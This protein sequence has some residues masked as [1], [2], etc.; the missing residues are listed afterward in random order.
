ML[1]RRPIRLSFV[2][3]LVVVSS[4]SV[5]SA[6]RVERTQAQ[7]YLEHV[8]YLA[9]PEL[10]GRGAG[11]PGLDLASKYIANQLRQFGLRPAGDT[12][13]Y[14]QPFQVTVTAKPGKNNQLSLARDSGSRTLQMESDYVPLSFSS[15]GSATGPVVFAGYGITASEFHYDDYAKLDVKDKIV[16]VLRY[17]PSYF[18]EA[19]PGKE[20]AYTHHS[21][22][23]SKAINAR[24]HGAKALIL[25][26][27]EL[28]EKREDKLIQFGTV[29]GP[30]N[31]GILMLQVKNGITNEWLKPAAK[32]LAGLR[33]EINEKREPRSFELPEAVRLNVQVDIERE[34]ATVNNV[35]G[36]L[37]GKSREYVIIGAHYDHLGLGNESSLAPS[38]IGTVHPGADDNASGT[39]AVLELARLFSERKEQPKR[40]ILFMTFA[41]EEIGLLGSSQWVNHP[42]LPLQDAVAMINMDMIGRVNGT[43]LYIGGT[44]T[45]STF[46]P[47]LKRVTG[48]YDFKIDYSQDGY[49]ASDHTSFASKSIPVLFFFSGLHGDYHKPSDTWD[50]ISATR[51]AE[52]VDLVYDVAT[53][54]VADESR[55][56]FK[57]VETG[58]HSRSVPGGSGGGYGPYF[59]SIPDFAPIEKGVKF[60]DVR[61]GSPAAKAGLQAG[62][63]LIGFG[64]KP[65]NNLYDFTFALRSSNV[66]DVVPVKFLRDGQEKTANVTLTPRP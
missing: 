5:A 27:G 41:G 21:H 24:N 37:P 49:S 63:I 48:D 18:R 6:K 31:V 32:V 54:L 34:H 7:H 26:N 1:I 65:I 29:S 30:E 40:G 52:V 15:N 13:T 38:Q 33:S 62:D 19:T 22:L 17:E 61:T 10:Q 36:Y 8:K 53:Q 58:L 25:V 50:K 51:A 20:K 66:G 16:L 12:G 3:A 59:G 47:L 35:A 46:E 4:L 23:V 28:D 57:K 42:T 11:T 60:S 56:Q 44:G 14:L 2:T 45:G 39:A 9:G 55:P 64:D 43:K